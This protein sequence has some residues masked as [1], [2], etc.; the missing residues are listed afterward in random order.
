MNVR[1]LN[2]KQ[3][4]AHI[5]VIVSFFKLINELVVVITVFNKYGVFSCICSVRH[6]K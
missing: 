4:V 2:L 6:M 3:T 1:L 5:Y